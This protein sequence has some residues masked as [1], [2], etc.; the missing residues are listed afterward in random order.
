MKCSTNSNLFCGIPRYISDGMIEMDE[1]CSIMINDPDKSLGVRAVVRR[2][3]HPQGNGDIASPHKEVVLHSLNCQ[4]RCG[5]S[6]GT[7]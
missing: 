2:D 5:E 1:G 7:K 6:R 3:A 4:G